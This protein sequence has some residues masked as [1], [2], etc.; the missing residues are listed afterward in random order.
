LE[1]DKQILYDWVCPAWRLPA[2]LM[3]LVP[4]ALVNGISAS[5]G[6]YPTGSASLIPADVTMATNAYGI[7]LI[8]GNPLMTRLR[9]LIRAKDLLIGVY[10]I[11]I[12]FNLILYFSSADWV[13]VAGCLGIGMA[14]IIG[15]LELMTCLTPI[16]MPNGERYRLYAVYYP[17]VLIF[18]PLSAVIST[19][20]AN[21]FNWQLNYLSFVF[22]LLIGMLFVIFFVRD[23]FVGKR[24]PLYQFDWLGMVFGMV[25]MLLISY[26]LSYGQTED[27]LN[28]DRIRG[29]I[30]LSVLL[31]PLLL[32]REARVRRPFYSLVPLG[33]A[34]VLIGLSFLFLLDIF[35]GA[36]T[37]LSSYM[38][39]L[40]RGNQVEVNQVDLWSM[41]GYLAG[42][43][44]CFLYYC[45]YQNYYVVVSAAV[46]CYLACYLQLYFLAG[47]NAAPQELYLP[48]FFRG[49]AILISYIST[50]LYITSAVP[51][52]HLLSAVVYFMLVRFF[53]APAIWTA[54]LGNL[55]YRRT[56]VDTDRLATLIDRLNPGA[57]DFS[58][59]GA[60]RRVELQASYLAFR[61]L[62]GMLIMTGLLILAVIVVKFIYMTILNR[63][64]SKY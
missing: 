64:M 13:L 56:I 24:I 35:L 54:V 14:K 33:Y 5:A 49:A 58:A 18:A 16:L 60:F 51:A 10:T 34:N 26:V 29:A 15:L 9:H 30:L 39:R 57:T 28:S 25:L 46:L 47:P 37:L 53:V 45:R 41:F 8:C 12:G 62:T 43:L 4:L 6:A 23:R 50:G 48:L 27:W 7:G 3:L 1:D 32:S 44:F 17:T 59:S 21:A 42:T 55:Y 38:V 61:E 36:G 31:L 52:K 20:V 63:K 40:L 11:L 2:L 19:T 22:L